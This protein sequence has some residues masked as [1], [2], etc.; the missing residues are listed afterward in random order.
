M[1]KPMVSV[2]I[3]VYNMIEYLD[4]CVES[5]LAQTYGK[6]EIWLVDDGSTDGSGR[7]CDTY[8]AGDARIRVIHRTNGGL[9][10]A[11]NTGL[12]AMKGDYVVFV[13]ADDY[14]RKDYVQMLLRCALRDGTDLV[15]G[16]HCKV[17]GNVAPTHRTPPRAHRILAGK[18]LQVWM[19]SGR[20]SMYAH[21]KLYK[22]ALFEK[23]RFP[24]GK[25]FED[26]PTLWQVLAQ[27]E[28]AS[29]LDV[30]LYYYR[31][32]PNSI[33]NADFTPARMDQLYAAEEIYREV[34]RDPVLRL[35]A[36]SRC[37]FS[38]ADNFTLVTKAY[39]RERRYLWLRICA[40]RRLVLQDT[41]ARASLKCMALLSYGSPYLVRLVGK[42]YKRYQQ[43]RRG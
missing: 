25:L 17:S 3:P 31:Q 34:K 6:L 19:L 22:A 14:V 1:K 18:Q 30:P 10:A 36:A 24:E 32:H 12:D 35:P 20:L 26:V 43:L 23:I 40:Y 8:A 27:T 16:S 38:A 9:S 2:I 28:Q 13:D 37:F 29:W 7:L 42:G 4:D 33:V 41:T 39:P 15:I 5:V 11:R 21:G